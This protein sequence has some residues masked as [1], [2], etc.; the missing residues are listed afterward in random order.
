MV[1]INEVLGARMGRVDA[2]GQ[3][4]VLSLTYHRHGMSLP[5]TSGTPVL[6]AGVTDEIELFEIP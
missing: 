4:L 3:D 6:P 1:L 2:S 5:I